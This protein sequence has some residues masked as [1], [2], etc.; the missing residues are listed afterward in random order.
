MER[1]KRL[2]MHSPVIIMVAN[3][4]VRWNPRTIP[5]GQIAGIP[6]RGMDKIPQLDGECHTRIFRTCKNAFKPIP[7]VVRKYSRPVVN[8]RRNHETQRTGV[9]SNLRERRLACRD[10]GTHPSQKTLSRDVHG[11]T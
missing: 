11:D 10:N 3:N 5:C 6:L 4:I 1:F 8:V 7:V 2:L 9:A